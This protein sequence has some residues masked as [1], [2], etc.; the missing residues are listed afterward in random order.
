M[1]LHERAHTPDGYQPLS[2]RGPCP[3]LIAV[4]LCNFSALAVFYQ[5]ELNTS[6]LARRH[7][8]TP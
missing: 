1:N 7:T 6:T 3:R 2:S 5:Q 8:W 4:Q